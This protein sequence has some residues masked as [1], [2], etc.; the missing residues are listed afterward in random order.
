MIKILSKLILVN[1]AIL[2]FSC[3]SSEESIPNNIINV[4]K[5]VPLIVDI[6]I[7]DGI[8]VSKQQ[9][10]RKSKFEYKDYH[11]VLFL[12]HNVT[13]SQFDSSIAFYSYNLNI[14]EDIYE[15]VMNELRKREAELKKS[16][17]QKAKN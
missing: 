17:L 10:S 14:Y 9:K 11:D 8:L 13:K 7:S 3:N 6:H 4:E 12:K 15:K 1:F 5:I 2:L 16:I